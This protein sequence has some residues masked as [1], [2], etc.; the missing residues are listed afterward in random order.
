MN[1]IKY[2]RRR[3]TSKECYDNVEGKGLRVF[4]L[5]LKLHSSCKGCRLSKVIETKPLNFSWYNRVEI[6]ELWFI[7]L[8][9]GM[10]L[11]H[12]VLYVESK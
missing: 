6:E 1:V 2:K 10:Y 5:F 4:K 7:V 8:L 12:I 9:K 11:I 3:R